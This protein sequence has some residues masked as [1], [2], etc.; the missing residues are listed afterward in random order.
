VLT[1][2]LS[3]LA[4]VC[5]GV[6][7]VLQHHGANRVPRRFPLHPGLLADVAQQPWW[8][9]GVVAEVVGVGLHMVAVNVG[10]LSV[11][12]PLLTLGLVVALPLQVLLGRRLRRRSLLAAALVV[13]GLAVFL[14]VRPSAEGRVPQTFWEW[15]PGLALAAVVGL[16]MLAIAFGGRGRV[17]SLGLGAAAGTFLATSAALVKTWGS[18]FDGGGGGLGGVGALA[19]SWQ[20]W[21]ALGCG[22]VGALLSLAAFQSGPLGPPLAAMM[23]VDPI[24][25]VSLGVVLYGEP[26]STGPLAVVQGAGLALT[27]AGVWLLA[28]G[29]R[30]AKT[31]RQE[32]AADD[33][34]PADAGIPARTYRAF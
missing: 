34:V 23:V 1:V 16:V 33:G 31:E 4:A 2:L 21:T 11:V 30:P 29:E 10:D 7:S 9:V 13:A 20:L 5:F 22:L 25:G 17:R 19:M 12:Q 27:L 24:L 32:P 26:F 15:A 3:L 18:L 8:L 14:V 6:A 28:A